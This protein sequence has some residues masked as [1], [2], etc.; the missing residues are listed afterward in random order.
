MEQ[1]V[2]QTKRATCL[3]NFVFIERLG[4]GSFSEVFLAK[5]RYTEALFAVKALKMK[6]LK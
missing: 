4:E 1:S 2:K 5:E 3:Q 6:K